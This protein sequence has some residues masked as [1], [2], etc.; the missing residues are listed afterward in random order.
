[1][2]L[3]RMTYCTKV[4]R[5]GCVNTEGAEHA[6]A[7]WMHFCPACNGMHYIAVENPLS[8]GAKWTFNGDQ[9][10]PTFH[11]SVLVFYTPEHHDKGRCHY[12]IEAGKIRYC[13]D[14]THVLAGKTV[15]LLDIP[16]YAL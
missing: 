5:D 1:M 14:C 2:K 8:N 7:G 9:A 16:E 13:G 12:F 10:L 15:D 4:G 3:R 11:P 6:D